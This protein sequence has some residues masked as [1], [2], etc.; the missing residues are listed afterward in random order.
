MNI[1][2]KDLKRRIIDISYRH[3][4]SHL[5]SCLTA[6]DIIDEIYKA[7]KEDEKF[8]LSSGHAGLALYCVI[9]KYE[10]VDAEKIFLHHGVHPDRCNQCHIDCSTGS[11][12]QGI[13]V[14]L[15]FALANRNRNVYALVSDGEVAEGSFWEALRI[16]H[17][18]YVNNL[19]IYVN[20]NGWGAYGRSSDWAWEHLLFENNDVEIRE[21]NVDDF[22]FL[23]GQEAHYYT[24]NETDYK[25]AM[26]NCTLII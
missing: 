24:M 11:L 10:G 1:T 12:G 18:L 8:V 26:E 25:E 7:K 23:E 13:N 5:G 9:E 17:D 16:K 22:P 20:W 19:K 2:N 6:V 3:K 4:L 14:A 15:G 21:T